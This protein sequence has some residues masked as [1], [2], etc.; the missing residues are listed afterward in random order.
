MGTL[1][2]LIIV[3]IFRIAVSHAD[4][5][6]IGDAVCRS[7][8]GFDSYCMSDRGVCHGVGGASIR[9]VCGEFLTSLMEYPDLD[10]LLVPDFPFIGRNYPNMTIIAVPGGIPTIVP[11]GTALP[12]GSPAVAESTKPAVPDAVTTQ[13]P[14]STKPAVATSASASAETTKA[15]PT[16]AVATTNAPATAATTAAPTEGPT[17]EPTAEPTA[18]PTP[19]PTTAAKPPTP[20]AYDGSSMFIW[21]EWPPMSGESDWLQY[22]AKLVQFAGSVKF[23][24]NLIIARVLDPIVGSKAVTVETQHDLWTVS[25]DSVFYTA[26]LSKLPSSVTEFMVYPYLMDQ[27]NRDHWMAAMGTTVPLKAVFKYCGQWNT[28][29]QRVG[30]KVKCV[31]VTV[32]GEERRGYLEE[33]S[34]VPSYKAEYAVSMFGY[35]TG[36]TQVGVISVY[37]GIVDAF[38]FELYDFYVRNAPSLQLVQ[39]SDVG[40]DD[41]NSFISLLDE[42]VWAQ[43]LPFYEATAVNFMWSVQNSSS[44]DCLYPDGPATCGIKEDFGAWSMDGYLNFLATL[45]QRYP[46][47]FGNKPHGIFQ[48]SFVPNSWYNNA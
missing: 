38:Y 14:A 15:A 9:C 6:I 24:T 7:K 23:K 17:A 46:T 48:F 12:T 19:A 31:G 43:Y 47:K 30:S 5:C 20:P 37:S 34:S 39:N 11:V 18:A 26:F 28:L 42:K 45:K 22:Y 27:Y 44:N 4:E 21:A 29:L 25:T 13:R 40:H 41:Y 33:M 32:D 35:A 3:S 2:Q 10:D 16:A 8:L 1:K 36:Y